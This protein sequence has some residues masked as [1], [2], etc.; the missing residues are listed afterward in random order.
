MLVIDI[1]NLRYFVGLLEEVWD[2]C[3]F[4]VKRVDLT[5]KLGNLLRK[6]FV[7]KVLSIVVKIDA[8]H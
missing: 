1:P 3:T 8:V 2:L 4:F 6:G 7:V 5:P